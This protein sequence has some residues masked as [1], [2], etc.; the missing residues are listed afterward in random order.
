MKKNTMMRIASCMLVAILLTTSVI[1]GTFAKY[2]SSSTGTDSARVA[3]WGFNDT[4]SITL[5]D[6]FKTSYDQ[7]V[8]GTS[9]VIAPGTTNEAKFSF[10]Y[11]GQ[12]AA[13]EVA[14][15]FT[16]STDGSTCAEDIQNNKNIVWSLDGQKAGTNGTWTELLAAIKALSGD[17][18]GTKTYSAG[19]TPQIGTT[20]E[21]TVSWAW[22]FEDTENKDAQD[23]KDTAMGNKAALDKV[24][25]KITVTATQVD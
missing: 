23:V 22:A 15:T 24:T 2:T 14:Y 20:T 1:S 4:A 7:N 18:T 13:P 16:V 19:Q 6:L 3:T 9:D 12:E 11:T 5:N 8:Q 17:S 21:H 10:K 25:L